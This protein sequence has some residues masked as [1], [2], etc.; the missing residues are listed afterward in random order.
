MPEGWLTGRSALVTGGASGIGR[1]SARALAAEGAR[2]CVA[3]L[4]GPG[5]E[6]VVKEIGAAGGEAF[7]FSVDVTSPEEN[8][9][10]VRAT[11][12]R[13]GGLG[14]AVLNAGIAVASSVHEG[15]LEDWDRVMAVNLRGVFLG[16][17]AS[18]KPMVASGSG[19]IVATA[20]VAGLIGGRGMPSYYASKHGVIGL[21]KAAAAE[22]ATR[23]IRVNAVCPGVIDTP[24]LGPVHGVPE[25]TEGVLAKIHPIGRV[26]RPEE[27][28]NLVVYLASDRASFIT[29]AA[30]PVDGGLLATL[31]GGGD[32]A[33][34]QEDSVLA[35]LSTDPAKA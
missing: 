29:G 11:V 21:V 30:Y 32:D 7:A 2:V 23:G 19:A 33:A 31:G 24:I 17:R 18:S 5:A 16:M 34:T 22:F 3:D 25:F 27:I 1:A 28:A 20:S 26:G 13:Y 35:N 15:S 9:E 8:E 10:M 14:I 4:N 12:S 6:D